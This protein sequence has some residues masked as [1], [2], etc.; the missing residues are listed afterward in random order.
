M[1]ELSPEMLQLVL[2]AVIAL[3]AGAV[4]YLFVN[5]YFSGQ[6]QRDKRIQGVTETKSKRASV[7][8]RDE[9]LQSRRKQ[10]ADTLKDIE[11]RQKSREKVTLRLQLQRSGLDV[12]PNSFWIASGVLGA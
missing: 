3:S 7:R 5:P 1:E 8:V 6:V 4:I 9:E 12:T 11:Q 2:G 10:V